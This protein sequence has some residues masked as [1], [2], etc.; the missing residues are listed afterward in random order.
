MF[1]V[2]EHIGQYMWDNQ[3]IGFNEIASE[4]SISLKAAVQEWPKAQP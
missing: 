3:R 1:M 2:K 4:M